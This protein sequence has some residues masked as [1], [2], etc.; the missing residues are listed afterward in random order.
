MIGYITIRRELIDSLQEMSHESLKVFLVFVDR[1]QQQENTK[2][3]MTKKELARTAD[4]SLAATERAM[5]WLVGQGML[6]STPK[7]KHHLI[8]V[9]E[10][11]LGE[12][13]VPIPYTNDDTDET[14][15]AKVEAELRR[16]SNVYAS[17][18]LGQHSGLDK[19]T[20]GEER[21][22]ILQIESRTGRALDVYDA[23]LLGKTFARF[24]AERTKETWRQMQRAKNP[25]R[26]VFAALR[27][28]AKG[29][30][31]K[32]VESRPFERVRYREVD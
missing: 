6:Q 1:H 17:R 3:G 13:P 7:G 4:L 5:I 19:I 14:K 23:F 22:L 28:G 8:A 12:K 16:M 26:A 9:H 27:N 15:I 11:W 18:A 30:P 24:G 2:L 32:V 10:W 25:I 21:D 20:E 29:Q 31:A